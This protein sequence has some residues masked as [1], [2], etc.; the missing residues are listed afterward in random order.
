MTS[1]AVPKSKWFLR[2]PSFGALARVFCVPY[3][4]CGASM[5]RRWP[6][7]A[8][9]VEFCPLQPPGR[10]NRLREKPYGAYETM[11]ADLADILAPYL[12]RPYALFGHCGSALAAYQVSAQLVESGR[13]APARLFVSSQVAP[14]DGPAGRF[15]RLTDRELAVELETLIAELGGKPTP[16]MVELSLEIL[17]VDIEANRRYVVSEPARLPC[18]ITAIGWS[19]DT[20]V[21]FAAMGGWTACGS[22]EFHLLSGRHHAFLDGPAELLDLFVTGLAR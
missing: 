17:K 20:E 6:Q 21:D 8:G 11:A 7:T 5:Y 13:P 2:P 12:D 10:E 9:G 15:L 1:P 18:P 22:T 19:E 14:Q 3:S 16:D 4:G